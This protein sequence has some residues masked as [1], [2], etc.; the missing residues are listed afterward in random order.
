[1]K[2]FVRA[3][4]LVAA[5]TGSSLSAFAENVSNPPAPAQ[6]PIVQHLK[7][8]NDQVAQIKKLHQQLENN[9]SQISMK[10]IKDGAVIDVIKSGKW[11]EAAVNKQLSA[12]SHVEQQARYYRVKYYFDLNKVLT[13]EQRKQVQK[14]IAQ[15]LS[16]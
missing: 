9:I 15:R 10:E 13:P 1:M 6:D 4:L 2:K 3:T 5:L 7:L 14:D 8:S 12:F 16:E 11:D